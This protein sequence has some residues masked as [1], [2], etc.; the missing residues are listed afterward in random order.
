MLTWAE[1]LARGRAAASSRWT[2]VVLVVLLAAVLVQ[3][4]DAGRRAAHEVARLAEAEVLRQKGVAVAE[5]K[6]AADLWA[7]ANKASAES[8]D[9]RAELARVKA[10]ARGARP[11]AVVTASTGSTSAAGAARPSPPSG[12]SAPAPAAPACLLA[13]GDRGEIRLAEA[14]LRTKGGNVVFAGAAEAWRLY[15]EPA[16]RLLAAPLRA[17]LSVEAP[18]R[19]AGWG[20]GAFTGCGRDGCGVGPA[21]ALPPL[22]AWRFELDV[23]AGV[24]FVGRL[25]A[26][27]SAIGRWR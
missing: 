25:E 22:R 10:A 27:A 11:V 6:S 18:E 20:L 5:Q 3:R 8:A 15:P 17:E 21:I 23:T 9:L 1:V 16:T 13:V 19:P 26:G 2:V 7:E 12:G 4:L 14:I 24:A